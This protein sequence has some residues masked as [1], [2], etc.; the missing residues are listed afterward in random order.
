MYKFL[1]FMHIM[2]KIRACQYFFI[3]FFIAINFNFFNL[4]ALPPWW[5]NMINLSRTPHSQRGEAGFLLLS[6]RRKP[7][8]SKY[9]PDPIPAF[10]GMTSCFF[11]CVC[12]G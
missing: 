7:G 3:L 5:K 2:L 1:L 9:I 11:L 12:S 4:L 6:S 8:L 10:A